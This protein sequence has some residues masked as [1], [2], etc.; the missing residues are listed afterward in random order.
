[1]K[2]EIKWI[3][4]IL[5]VVGLVAGYFVIQYLPQYLEKGRSVNVLK[6]I[7]NPE[8]YQSWKIPAGSRCADAP[9][10]FPTD[11][12]VGYIWDDSFRPGHRHS[13]ID[14]FSGTKSGVTPIYA[15][16][17][18]YLTRESSW[19]S[20]VIIRI[21]SDPLHPGQQIWTYYTHMADEDGNSYVSEDFPAG[22]HEV[23][24]EA[25]TLLGYVGNF[26]GTPGSP[27]GVHLH[28]SIVK[29]DG[30]GHYMNETEIKNTLDPSPYL[31]LSLNANINKDQ[32]PVCIPSTP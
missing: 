12:F 20:T 21:P 4:S 16:A 19:I 27:T 18:G 8:D 28:L 26:S 25:G 10:Q 6:F 3:L 13:G 9:F 17:D 15:V 29:D 30:S 2:K 14:V 31:G 24:V 11:G 23:F 22:T 7:R 1:M 32:I 5:I